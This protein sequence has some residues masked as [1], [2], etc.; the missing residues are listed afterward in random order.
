MMKI[1]SCVC[2]VL[3]VRSGETLKVEIV[4][5]VERIEAKSADAG[6]KCRG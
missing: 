1:G 5:M 2:W 3:Y 6:K 4:E